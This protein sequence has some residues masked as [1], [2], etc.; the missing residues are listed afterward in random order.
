MNAAVHQYEDKLLEFAYGELPAHEAA[1]VDA[2]VKGCPRC[3]DA[4]AQIQSVRSTMSAL[5]M[6]PAPDAGLESL[7]AYAE[8]TAKRH[9]QKTKDVWWRRYLMPLAS[10]AA[11]TVVGVVAW[12]ASQE[13]NPDPATVALEMAKERDRKTI[14]PTATSEVMEAQAGA[15]AEGRAEGAGT[16]RRKADAPEP[17]YEEVARQGTSESEGVGG[18]G[19][20]AG[21]DGFEASVGKATTTPPPKP[22][23]APLSQSRRD[24]KP[25]PSKA[26][27][28]ML[29]KQALADD[30]SNAALR[31]VNESAPKV[32]GAAPKDLE[33]LGEAP[34]SREPSMNQR[35]PSNEAVWGLGAGRAVG[36]GTGTGAVL[37]QADGAPA[38]AA[39]PPPA[40]TGA[41]RAKGS[42][43]LGSLSSRGGDGASSGDAEEDAAQVASDSRVSNKEALV[44]EREQAAVRA[45]YLL[46]A[47]AARNRNDRMTEVTFALEVLN[48]GAKG[49][50]RL[51]AL[52]RVCDAYEAMGQVDRAQSYCDAVLSEF[53]DSAA[54]QAVAQRRNRLPRSPA[55]ARPA[56]DR[57]DGLD[58]EHAAEPARAAPAP[59]D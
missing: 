11:L 59:A 24:A 55:P 29:D 21:A 35:A 38:P 57:K 43:Q 46:A 53:P 32:K 45:K 13:F 49:Q 19:L 22:S 36:L 42:L 15:V 17:R 5:P 50:E 27:Q 20:R 33:S 28:S 26:A 10:A 2:H 3:A 52:E 7:L 23:F 34:A 47:R 40:S 58:E 14:A 48:L 9:A 8:Q 54:A 6:V 31:G 56:A 44:R 37:P 30:V 16:E 39:A 4:L 51:E 12:R 1:A 18:G 25:V 41:P